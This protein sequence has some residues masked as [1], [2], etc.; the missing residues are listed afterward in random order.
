MI[1]NENLL[2]TGK[3]FDSKAAKKDEKVFLLTLKCCYLNSHKFEKCNSSKQKTGSKKTI[4]R[5]KC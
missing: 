1:K 5:A 3:Y 4:N 2:L